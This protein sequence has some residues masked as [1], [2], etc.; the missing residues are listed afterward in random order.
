MSGETAVVVFSSGESIHN[1]K[2][3][4]T[5]KKHIVACIPPSSSSSS[6]SSPSQVQS[7]LHMGVNKRRNSNANVDPGGESEV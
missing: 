4:G 2:E 3:L 1:S 6:S 7:A 5:I